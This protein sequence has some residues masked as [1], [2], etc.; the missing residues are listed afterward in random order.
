M[1]RFAPSLV[2]SLAA[3]AL[4]SGCVGTVTY[5]VTPDEIATTA[6]NALEEQVGSLP[7][8]DCGTDEIELVKGT[9]VDC[10]LTDPVSGDQ[11]DA[12]VTIEEVNGAEYTIGIQVAAEPR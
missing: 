8:I 10:V 11:F 7:E 5:T 9:V 2:L 6:A 4:L 3:I 12:P 1:T